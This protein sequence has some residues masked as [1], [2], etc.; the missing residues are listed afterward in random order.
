MG[1][2]LS[3]IILVGDAAKS[4][5]ETKTEELAT[6]NEELRTELEPLRKIQRDLE[7]T[8]PYRYD[9][10]HYK[11]PTTEELT[12]EVKIL[13]EIRQTLNDCSIKDAK[14]LETRLEK[15]RSRQ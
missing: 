13:C 14:E 5:L 8:I 4:Y 2:L 12:A 9:A 15:S 10:D 3:T 6:K 11:R 7:R 1:M